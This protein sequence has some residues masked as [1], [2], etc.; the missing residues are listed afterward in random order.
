M[1]KRGLLLQVLLL[2]CIGV[3][4]AQPLPTT[5]EPVKSTGD[6]PADMII[7]SSKKYE[8]EKS[9]ISRDNSKKDRK[10]IESFY[11]SANFE[12]DKLLLSGMVSFNDPITNY[13]NRIVDVL[14]KDEPNL[15]NQVRVYTMKSTE[16]NAFATNQGIIFVNLGLL[17]RIK[18]EAELA[19]VL[20]HEIT[21]IEEKHSLNK[22]LKVQTIQ[23]DKNLYK[24]LSLDDKLA[25]VNHYS[26]ELETEADER[27]LTRFLK[28][29][30][31]LDAIEA[32]FNSLSYSHT[33]YVDS[34]FDYKWLESSTFT[35]PQEF[36][37]KKVT[38]VTPLE[39]NDDSTSTHPS[40]QQRKE[41]ILKKIEGVSSEGRNPSVVSAEELDAAVQ[42]AQFEVCRLHLSRQRYD[43]A[44][45]EAQSLL[46][47]YPNNLYLQKV[48][49]KALAAKAYIV[50][51]EIYISEWEDYINEDLQGNQQRCYH[52][53]LSLATN[54]EYIAS[55]AARFGWQ[56]KQANP[57]DK[58]IAGLTDSL[59]HL[60]FYRMEV[61]PEFFSSSPRPQTEAD[62]IAL[63]YDRL[64]NPEKYAKQDSLLLAKF[65]SINKVIAIEVGNKPNA[66]TTTNGPRSE[67]RSKEGLADETSAVKAPEDTFY[68][69][70]IAEAKKLKIK[71]T[72]YEK[73]MLKN[74]EK[75]DIVGIR[76]DGTFV[77]KTPDNNNG[78]I[79]INTEVAIKS[80]VDSTSRVSDS[81]DSTG[82][83]AAVDS[84]EI[85]EELYMHDFS[86]PLDAEFHKYAFVD[87]AKDS[88][89]WKTANYYY[90]LQQK[91]EVRIEMLSERKKKQK[92]DKQNYKR[93]YA[94]NI[95]KVV[96]VNPR[97][98]KI[99]FSNPEKQQY[100]T[101]EKNQKRFSNILRDNADA[102][103]IDYVLIDNK[104]LNNKEVNT[105]N[106]I[107]FLSEWLDER[108]E[109]GTTIPFSTL[110]LSEREALAEKYG[111]RY[112]MWTGN[113]S[114][115][116]KDYSRGY[117]IAMCIGLW[118]AMPFVLPSIIRGGKYQIYYYLVYDIISNEMVLGD[119]ITQNQLERSDFL[120]SQVYFTFHQLNNKR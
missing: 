112:F 52:F 46:K 75:Y 105:F 81:D 92:E 73:Y 89:F 83:I 77:Y 56:L 18:S 58:E 84:A 116:E 120:N 80:D 29:G 43:L 45:Y 88:A 37:R 117:K 109:L 115:K 118:P 68:V 40:I 87:F 4:V 50:F 20:A 25:N 17:A 51:D 74:K 103:N 66:D 26:R 69:T 61:D 60:L 63:A 93:G 104:N 72:G 34:E 30:Y 107:A 76:L 1:L 64:N 85:E 57:N 91:D 106:D 9:T 23:R 94:L 19:F 8:V 36:W 53:S 5:Y 95:D 86:E 48:T 6:I 54:E 41:N 110:E 28:A 21:H 108:L 119:V 49:L 67:E 62:S 2:F 3:V 13:L 65:D 101:S 102:S 15:R 42:F 31:S 7:K 70:T 11:L 97:Y 82:L 39:D 27:G 22:Y 78:D 14:L 96:I 59:M 33:P 38:T 90:T 99:N 10:T 35:F 16:M 12:I 44:I 100:L 24:G 111:T 71:M 113:L 55:V 114:V 47:Q 79:N 32:S 98:N